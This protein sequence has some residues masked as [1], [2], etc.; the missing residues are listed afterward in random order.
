MEA[1]DAMKAALLAPLEE[2]AETMRC[3]DCDGPL[4]PDDA[5]PG[6]LF[7]DDCD[8]GFSPATGAGWT[9]GFFTRAEDEE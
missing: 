3:P 9:G 5:V 4:R 7:C 1:A 2:A 6:G 8:W